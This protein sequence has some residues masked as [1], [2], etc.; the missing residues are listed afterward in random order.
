MQFVGMS[1]DAKKEPGTRF[2]ITSL[3]LTQADAV[4]GENLVLHGGV[5]E[6]RRVQNKVFNKEMR[7]L[8]KFYSE[9]NA[10]LFKP[11]VGDYRPRVDIKVPS[12]PRVE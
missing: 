7:R 1:H 2:R 12:R 9:P 6:V 5:L 4:R 11:L 3:E 8:R 10:R